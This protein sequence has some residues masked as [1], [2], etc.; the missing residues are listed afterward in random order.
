MKS[1]PG[2]VNRSMS[3]RQLS[4]FVAFHVICL[5]GLSVRAQTMEVEHTSDEAAGTIRAAGLPSLTLDQIVSR[6]VEANTNRTRDLHSY[7]G[8]RVYQLEYRGFLTHKQAALTV[9][10]QYTA[11]RTK[12]FTIE[13]ESGSRML[14]NNVLKQLLESEREAADPE[15]Q[16]KAA[17]TPD[18]YKFTLVGTATG[19]DGSCYRLRVEPHHDNKFLYRGEICVDGTDFAVQSIDAEPSKNPSFW[20]S[21][22][23]IQHRYVKV[24]EFWLPASNKSISKVRLGGTATLEINYLDYTVNPTQVH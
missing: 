13:S 6:L 14:L 4:F 17:L 12:E 8:K 23:K 7:T 11:P 9:S 15:N 22:T 21:D 19:P 1:R 3:V 16:R 10:S 20:I 2:I 24:G 5:M 18:N